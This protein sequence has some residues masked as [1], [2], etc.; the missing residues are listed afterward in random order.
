M[1]QV[2]MVRGFREIAGYLIDNRIFSIHTSL[3][4][5]SLPIYYC[6]LS[7]FDQITI[8]H[9]SV[10]P[11]AAV[12][13][14]CVVFSFPSRVFSDANRSG[15]HALHYPTPCALTGIGYTVRYRVTLLTVIIPYLDRHAC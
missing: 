14:Y 3:C 13:L 1:T 9:T 4:C 6:M 8:F 10:N 12:V 15:Y 7:Y 5:I 2:F 11:I